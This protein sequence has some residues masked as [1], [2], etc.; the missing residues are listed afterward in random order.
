MLAAIPAFRVRELIPPTLLYVPTFT[1]A[2]LASTWVRIA[3]A[4]LQ[5]F[6]YFNLAA[7]ATKSRLQPYAANRH[8]SLMDTLA[9]P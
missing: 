1:T 7:F 8:L 4:F 6:S 2:F 9:F 3:Y 5:I